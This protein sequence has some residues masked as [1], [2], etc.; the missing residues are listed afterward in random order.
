MTAV[1]ANVAPMQF[2]PRIV[3]P[4]EYAY[5][6]VNGNNATYDYEIRVFKKGAAAGTPPLVSKGT[7]VNAGS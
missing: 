7:I 6:A 5:D 1:G 4:V 2:M 3:S